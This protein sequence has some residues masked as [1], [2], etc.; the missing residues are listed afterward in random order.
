MFSRLFM[1]DLPEGFP[2]TAQSSR[3]QKRREKAAGTER[4]RRLFSQSSGRFANSQGKN[5]FSRK[6]R[7]SLTWC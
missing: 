4:A 3:G 5:A 1:I 2:Q 6:R 7:S